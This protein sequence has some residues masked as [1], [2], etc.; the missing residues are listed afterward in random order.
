[1]K[2]HEVQVDD[3]YALMKPR[4]GEFQANDDVHFSGAG[5]ALIAGQVAKAILE[6]L[7]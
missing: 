5:S 7:D 6:E 4:Q 2:K 3:L 1:M